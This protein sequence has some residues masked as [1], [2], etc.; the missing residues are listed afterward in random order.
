MHKP[1][2]QCP[3]MVHHHRGKTSEGRFDIDLVLK[4]L[5]ILP[6]QTI[7]D[8]GCGNGYMAKEF[9]K[10]L[11]WTGK[12]YALDT[13]EE[14]IEVLKKETKGTNI[15]PIVSDITRRTPLESSCVDLIYMSNVFHGFSHDEVENLHKEVQR[16]LKPKGL[17]IILEIKK[18]D[19][20]F[21][22]PMNIRYSSQELE[23]IIKLPP[24]ATIELGTYFY[25]KTFENF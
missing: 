5:D 13:D 7:I 12:V 14:A 11:G 15:T 18:E 17:L 9:S 8:A 19:T 23:Q 3:P 6:G 24:K 20:P 21:G 22:P 10:L 2:S 4:A 1:K 25:L 16:L